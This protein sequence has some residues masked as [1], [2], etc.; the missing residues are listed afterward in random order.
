MVLFQDFITDKFGLV[1][2]KLIRD[3]QGLIWYFEVKLGL[4]YPIL[5]IIIENDYH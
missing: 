1:Y 5:Q 2:K 3:W 4:L